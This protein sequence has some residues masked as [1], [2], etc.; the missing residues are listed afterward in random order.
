[1]IFQNTQNNNS[2][3]GTVFYSGFSIF[4]FSVFPHNFSHFKNHIQHYYLIFFHK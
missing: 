1:M 2:K 3:V 4:K